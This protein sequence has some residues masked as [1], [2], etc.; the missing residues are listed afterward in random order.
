MTMMMLQILKLW[1]D[2]KHK[3][4]N[5]LRKNTVFLSNGKKAF[6]KRQGLYNCKK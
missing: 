5:I 1:I 2:Q 4:L 3:N 6:I